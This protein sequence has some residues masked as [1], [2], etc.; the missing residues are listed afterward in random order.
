MPTTTNYI[1]DEQNYLAEA[2][3][4]NVIQNV[5]TNEPQG[6]GNL[7]SSRIGGTTSYHEFDALGSTRQLTNSGGSTTDTAIY[8][9][10]GNVANRTG[11]TVVPFVWLAA[12]G[13]YYDAESGLSYVRARHYGPTIARWTAGD[14][15]RGDGRVTLVSS[16]YAYSGNSPVGR[17]DPAGRASNGVPWPPNVNVGVA[18]VGGNFRDAHCGEVA[19]VL[20]AFTMTAPFPCDGYIVQQVSASCR[21][22]GCLSKCPTSSPAT[23]DWTYW[24]AWPVKAG[25][26]L[27]PLDIF[28]V[29]LS[30]L[31]C[32]IRS[33]AAIVKFFCRT[34]LLGVGCGTGDL[35]GYGQRP[36]DPAS[37]WRPGPQYGFFPCEFLTG[38]L[39][40]IGG[41]GSG[42]VNRPR[43]WNCPAAGSGTSRSIEAFWDCCCK[44]NVSIVVQPL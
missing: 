23:P 20:A 41:P 32:G 34:D 4:S 25:Q 22:Q 17:M 3:A 30:Q 5:Y 27:S 40:S 42:D 6:Y 8:D 24:E 16:A 29:R 2:S 10:W 11:N 38:S 1:W 7:I 31:R 33:I 26:W 21:V 18:V 43:W 9:A 37:R 44:D 13:Y 28:S 39:P 12:V 14:T 19:N 36:A 35:G 15:L